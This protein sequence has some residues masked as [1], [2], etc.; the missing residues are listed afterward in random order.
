MANVPYSGGDADV[1][2]IGPRG[3]AEVISGTSIRVRAAGH[4]RVSNGYAGIG[5]SGCRPGIS[6][7]SRREAH[8][9][10]AH[11]GAGRLSGVR[12]SGIRSR[13]REA[14]SGHGIT[15]PGSGSL[16]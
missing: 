15:V 9:I 3:S 2:P 14:L 11:T 5:P 6:V 13:V 8:R 10:S 16:A 4:R 12:I 7:V 1:L